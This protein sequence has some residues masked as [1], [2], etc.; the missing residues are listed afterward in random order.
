MTKQGLIKELHKAA[1]R[2]FRTLPVTLKGIND[3]LQ[4]DLV[5]VSRFKKFNKNHTFILMVINAFSKQAFAVPLKNKSAPV[6]TKAFEEI[7]NKIDQPVKNLLTDRGTEFYNSNFQSLMKKYKINH[8]STFSPKKATIVERLNRTLMS[9]IFQAFS[10]QGSYK[11]LDVLPKILERYNNKIHRTIKMRP[12]DVKG[13]KI[14]KKLLKEVY[15]RARV[16]EIPKFKVGD[17]VR[18]SKFKNTFEKGYLPS[19]ST[20]LFKVENVMPTSPVT[21]RLKDLKDST[22]AGNFYAE[23]LQKTK[24]P[25]TYLV[26]KI[27]KTKGQ[28]VLVKWL[29]F[30]ETSWVSKADLVD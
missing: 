29:G 28:K 5:D 13:P 11:W 18:I 9:W 20:E 3:L 7:L 22:V 25:D 12:N 19:W 2:N 30:D 24:F 10:L 23:E 14:E 15:N 27:L 17:L 1:R 16:L 6:V 4:A 8:Y 21:Y 26:E